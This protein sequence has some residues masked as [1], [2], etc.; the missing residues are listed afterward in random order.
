MHFLLCLSRRRFLGSYDGNQLSLAVL[1]QCQF[2]SCLHVSA[3]V[4][5]VSIHAEEQG[6]RKKEEREEEWPV[7]REK[8]WIKGWIVSF[9]KNRS[10]TRKSRTVSVLWIMFSWVIFTCGVAQDTIYHVAQLPKWEY[11]RFPSGCQISKFRMLRGMG[12][13]YSLTASLEHLFWALLGSDVCSCCFVAYVKFVGGSCLGP[14][15]LFVCIP[16]T[17]ICTQSPQNAVF[18]D[19]SK[20]ECTKLNILEICP[21]SSSH[22]DSWSGIK[23]ALCRCQ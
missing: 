2:F 8:K 7:G 11:L 6:K 3:I 17:K 19:N 10:D 14:G 13:A 22:G 20:A 15:E 4:N 23:N 1:L 16:P 18:V 5:E 12:S 9:L 21:S